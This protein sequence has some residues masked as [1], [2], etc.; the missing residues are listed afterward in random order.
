MVDPDVLHELFD[1][2]VSLPPAD[3]AAFLARACGDNSTLREQV[4]RLLAADVQHATVFDT[5]HPSSDSFDAS[6]P[7]PD[8]VRLSLKE[9]ARLGAYQILTALGAGGMGEV[10]RARDTRLDRNVA[11]KV[12]PPGMTSDPAARQRLEREARA[13][14]ALAHPHI[15]TLL[16][17]GRQDDVDYLVM[18]YL[19]G[20]TLAERLTRGKLPL[21]DALTCAIQIAEAL[22][23]AH[24]ADIVHR[25]LKPGNIM[26]TKAG[27]KLLDFGLAKR[28]HTALTGELRTVH[29]QPVTRTGV[30]LG[31]IQYMA[32]EQ[33][34]GNPSDARSDIFAFGVVLYELLTGRRAFDGAS[35]ASL[36]GNILHAEPPAPSFVAHTAPKQLDDLVRQCLAKDPAS[37]P[38]SITVVHAQLLVVREQARIPGRTGAMM[39]SARTR[40]RRS[41]VLAGAVVLL[42]GVSAILGLRWLPGAWLDYVSRGPE[43]QG[44]SSN[45]SLQPMHTVPLTTMPGVEASP[46]FS[47]DGTHIALASSSHPGEES[48]I[49]VKRI[50][51]DS[52]RELTHGAA[53]GSPAWS[54]DG[55]LIAFVRN[56][57][58]AAGRPASHRALSGLYIVPAIGGPVRRLYSATLYGGPA[59]SPDGRALVFSPESPQG[60]NLVELSMDTLSTRQLTS[61]AGWDDDPTFSPDG[62]TLAFVH[63]QASMRDIYLLPSRGGTPKRLTF[64]KKTI[65][66]IGWAPDGK[67]IIFSSSRAGS[68][69]LW[70]IT[71]EGGPPERLPIAGGT[72]GGVALDRSGR[73]LA[74]VQGPELKMHIGA[75]KLHGARGAPVNIAESSRSEQSPSFS[76]DG[77]RIAF[78]SDRGGGGVDIWM[79][80]ADGTNP[81]RLTFFN[82]GHSGSPQWSPDGEWVAFDSSGTDGQGDVLTVRT[83]GGAPRRLT[84]GGSNEYV[85]SWS[86]DGRWI[87]FGSD[88]TGKSQVWKM[89]SDGGEAIQ[90]TKDGG[91]GGFESHDGQFLYYTKGNDQPGVWRVPVRGGRE[92]PVLAEDPAGAYGRCWALVDR[93]L[94]Y[95]NTRN[96]NR[97]SVEFLDLATRQIRRVLDLPRAACA[98]YSPDLAVSPDE[99]TLLTCFPG[100]AESD[101]MLVENFR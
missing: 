47:P 13:A 88:R 45:L 67:A 82:K 56:G 41:V 25:D 46:S 4:E 60:A 100:A 86:R 1:R 73:R 62:N 2:A 96:Q 93:R 36:I 98:S 7:R 11:I 23:T 101:I 33:L 51:D 37:R 49:L 55:R 9:G 24:E 99:G 52:P 43:T 91:L 50:G 81:I 30:I 66:G 89:P 58:P 21:D 39:P 31:T 76:S 70:R 15:C 61:T 5:A 74:Y 92:E 54:P 28:R 68:A 42:A 78:G 16:D 35:D 53:D 90:I 71:R 8:T 20:E 63:E 64:D 14:A 95:L 10:Y 22:D 26:L 85:P 94:Y 87:Y 17:I 69:E 3:R 44:P 40:V 6:L 27:A 79:A 80:D 75:V 12:L 18:E 29:A 34:E 84:P 83:A 48:K 97:Q 72:Y 59:W 65:W 32:P 77:K 57:W 19:E 38:P